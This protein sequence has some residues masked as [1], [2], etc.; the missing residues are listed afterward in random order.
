MSKIVS[1]S[2][3]ATQGLLFFKTLEPVLKKYLDP[4]KD[5]SI[6]TEIYN[7]GGVGAAKRLFITERSIFLFSGKDLFRIEHLNLQIEYKKSGFWESF[8]KGGS[9]VCL[10]DITETTEDEAI[11]LA[12]RCITRSGLGSV[13]YDP[14]CT[15]GFAKF[16]QSYVEFL[17]LGLKDY[18]IN[19]A[20]FFRKNKDQLAS[21][22]YLKYGPQE[23]VAWNSE[24]VFLIE[25][26]FRAIPKNSLKA[27]LINQNQTDLIQLEFSGQS[28]YVAAYKSEVV[29][30]KAKTVEL[31]NKIFDE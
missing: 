2:S 26:E 7:V 13:E 14:D 10:K 18:G 22:K 9:Y 1:N 5:G 24:K 25:D 16:L 21:K 20:V 3:E 11:F 27:E 29:I 12:G 19:Y 28:Y 30:D 15:Q 17:K 6:L 8:K 4:I 31:F 23:M